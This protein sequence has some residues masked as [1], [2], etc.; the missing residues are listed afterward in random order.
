MSERYFRKDFVEAEQQENGDW[1]VTR[2]D[3][4]SD[5][6]SD[7]VLVPQE[8]FQKFFH[9]DEVQD[10]QHQQEASSHDG[11]SS[12]R[13]QVCEACGNSAEGRAGVQQGRPGK[14]EASGSAREVACAYAVTVDGFIA[15]S[16]KAIRNPESPMIVWM[17]RT[18]WQQLAICATMQGQ[19]YIPC[20]TQLQSSE[21]LRLLVKQKE[22][23]NALHSHRNV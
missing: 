4:S 11:G 17:P 3:I 7:H 21:T 14:T 16:P 22:N 23:D 9:K 10:A 6:W 15:I 12:T 20:T 18:S 5:K 19:F 8:A 2:Y 1:L 13:Q